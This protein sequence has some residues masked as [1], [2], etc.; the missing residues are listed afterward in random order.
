MGDFN[1]DLLQY[2]FQY[3]NSLTAYFRTH[4]P[5]LFQIQLSL[6]GRRNRRRGRGARE[7][8]KNEGDWLNPT[9][10]TSYSAT[11]TD[12]IVTNNLS[13]NIFNRI[14]LNDL[15]DHLPVFTYFVNEAL[16]CRREKKILSRAIN[17][18]NLEKFNENL[19][20]T[21]WSSFIKEGDPN[22]AFNN[23]IS[24]F[25]RIYDV[26]FPLKVIKGKQKNKFNSP[27]LT[28]GLLKSINKKNRLY[29]KL[30]RSPTTSCELKYKPYKNKLNHLIRIAKR[31]YYDSKLEDAKNDLRAK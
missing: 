19:S 14:V 3:R 12:N 20:N 28:R 11:L 1:L 22:E 24:E 10:L 4:F 26:C 6:R 23:F 5:P 2:T 8:R 29:K 18:T 31:T 15:S 13:Q 9:R 30:V 25:S 17:N 21:N 16:I 27:W 7:A